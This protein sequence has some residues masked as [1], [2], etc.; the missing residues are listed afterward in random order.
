M[1]AL[2]IICI[3]QTHAIICRRITHAHTHTH[4]YMRTA[5]IT[6]RS[7]KVAPFPRELL[8]ACG[9]PHT[10][11]GPQIPR[12]HLTIIYI[13]IHIYIYT[14][15]Y[16]CVCLTKRSDRASSFSVKLETRVANVHAIRNS[17]PSG[18]KECA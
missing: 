2:S 18:L 8:G 4:A 13:Y 16:V 11:R 9:P 10:S 17:V 15:I 6:P 1:T 14:Y 3:V 12:N 7:S 5:L